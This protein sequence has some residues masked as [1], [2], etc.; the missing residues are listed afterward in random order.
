MLR[1]LKFTKIILPPQRMAV[2][3]YIPP[4]PATLPGGHAAAVAHDVR[5]LTSWPAAVRP[6]GP[7]LAAPSVVGHDVMSLTSWATT[8]DV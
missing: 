1:K 7:L 4:W 8:A 5:Y 6:T 2:G 3:P